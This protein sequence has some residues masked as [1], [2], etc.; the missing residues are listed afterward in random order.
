[1]KGASMDIFDKAIVFAT[2]AHSGGLR[3]GT[4]TPYITHPM[5]VAAIVATM[6]DDKDILAAAILHDTVEDTEK[7]IDDIRG[8]FGEKIARLVATESENKRDNLPPEATWK[9]RKQ[10]TLNHLKS[11]TKEEKMITLGDKLS[12]IRAIY[13]DYSTIGDELWK[14]FNQKDKSEHAWYY[15][16]IAELLSELNSTFAYKE[17]VELV[18][19]VFDK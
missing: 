7:T 19:K 16:T 1:M 15:K 9:I 8:E 4:N 18:N 6:T 11:A 14:R 17:Y 12:N 10:E 2:K 3:K 5:E 13:R